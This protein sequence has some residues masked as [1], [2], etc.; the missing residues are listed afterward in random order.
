MSQDTR[1]TTTTRRALLRTAPAAG[2]GLLAAG[3]TVNAVAAATADAE[4]LELGR[5]MDALTTEYWRIHELD[6]PWREAYNALVEDFRRRHTEGLAPDGAAFLVEMKDIEDRYRQNNPSAD[7]LTD[8]MDTPSRR[9]M[10]LSAFTPAGLAVKARAAAFACDHFYR[11]EELHDADWD[12]QHVR[13]LI[14]GVLAMAGEPPIVMPYAKRPSQVDPALAVAIRYLDAEKAYG[15][16]LERRA[17]EETVGPA[18]SDATCAA[19]HA[20]M[21]A[22]DAARS[23]LFGAEPTTILGVAA[24]LE[25][26]AHNDDCESPIEMYVNADA[27]KSVNDFMRRLAGVLREAS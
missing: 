21:H 11:E 3:T 15:K 20:A 14:D 27:G 7:D 12:H 23:A 2:A 1:R 10:A 4:L 17:H 19:G 16:A 9:I 13:T 5:R 25:A 26:L 6:A 22:A 18:A 24:L 8:A